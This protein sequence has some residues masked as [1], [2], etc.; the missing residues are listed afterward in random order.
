MQVN[1]SDFVTDIDSRKRLG[2]RRLKAVIIAQFRELLNIGVADIDSLYVRDLDLLKTSLKYYIVESGEDKR[3]INSSL[4]KL[5]TLLKRVIKR[6][7]MLVKEQRQ[8][9]FHS[10][11]FRSNRTLIRKARAV[12]VS[13]IREFYMSDTMSVGKIDIRVLEKIVN[14]YEK[15]LRKSDAGNS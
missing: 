2:F 3:F 15:E 1:V 12:A 10:P 11:E 13:I 7:N 5:E 6:I 4:K 8:Y 14:A 9:D